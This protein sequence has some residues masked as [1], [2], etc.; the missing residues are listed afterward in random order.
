MSD[1]HLDVPATESEFKAGNE[2]T[3]DLAFA[4]SSGDVDAEDGFGVWN[5][6]RHQYDVGQF[7][8]YPHHESNDV[9][10]PSVAAGQNLFPHIQS[11][12]LMEMQN[13][14][15]EIRIFCCARPCSTS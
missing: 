11:D 3:D 10:A 14:R 4:H 1:K 12:A 15:Y 7:Q 13:I 5:R 8:L 9:V 2:V 6:L